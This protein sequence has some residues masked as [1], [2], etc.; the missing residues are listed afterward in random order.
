[1]SRQGPY[2]DFSPGE[3]VGESANPK[4]DPPA[5][6]S[7]FGGPPTGPDPVSVLTESRGRCTPLHPPRT[8]PASSGHGPAVWVASARF[9]RALA[10]AADS[11]PCPHKAAS[12][13]TAVRT[14]ATGLALLVLLS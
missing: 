10:P 14:L 3:G 2:E 6:A 7:A 12:R 1:M 9:H 5:G 8:V 11:R 4:R 13:S